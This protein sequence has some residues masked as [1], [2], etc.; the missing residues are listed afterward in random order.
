MPVT[1]QIK[2]IIP[3]NKQAI[4]MPLLDRVR[5]LIRYQNGHFYTEVQCTP[6]VSEICIETST[7]SSLAAWRSWA[8][9]REWQKAES[10]IEELLES[11]TEVRVV[12]AVNC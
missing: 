2:R 7:W 9:S 6:E 1:I 5:E 10:H 4:A 12:A 8:T 3:P 11:K